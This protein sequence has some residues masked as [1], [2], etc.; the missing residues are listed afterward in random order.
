MCGIGGVFLADRHQT[1]D[2]QLL[3]NM[4]AIQS[5]RGPDGFGVECLDA[6]GVG[7][8][9]ARLS[10]ID[11]NESRARQPFLSNDRQVL[12]A[13]NG[14][15]YD[16]QRIRADLTAQGVRFSSKSDSEIL[17]RLY[18]RQGLESTLPLLRG[19]FAFA[20]FDAADD[21]LYL[22]RDRFGIKPQYWT[23]TPEG[24]VFGSELKVLFAHPAVERRFTS[25]GLFH[26]L[27]Q[28][29][30][31][32]TTAFA[33]VHQVQPGHVLKVQRRGD[34][35]EV[36]KSTY[37]DVDFPRLDQRDSTLTE[38]DHIANVRAALLEAVEMRMV[39][40]VPVGCYLSGGIDSCSI[41]G[42][43]SA[44]SQGPVKAFTIGFD[45]ARYD[46]TPIAAEMAEATGAEQDVM[47]LSG[48][49]LYGHMEQTLWHTERTIYN[50]LAVAKYLMSRHVNSVDYKVVMTGEGS[51]ELFG[52]Y[53]AFRRDMFLH[54][55]EA[56]PQNDRQDWESLLQTNNSLVQGAML[57]ADQVDDPDLD[58]VVGF[59]PSCLQPWLACAPLVPDLLADEHRQALVE[60]SPGKAIAEQL[61][62]QQ[63]D[64]RHALDK[65]QY[66]WIKT[67]L[68]GQIL[69]WGGDR[70]D[71]ANSMEA[72]PAFLDHHLAAAAVQVPPELRIKGKTEKY[73]LR[74]AMAGL[75]PEV[76]YKREKFAFMAPPAHT[77]PE[78]WAQMKQLAD[79]YL[80]DEAIDAAGLLSKEG[81]SA[82]FARHDDP[83]TTD[84]ERVQMDAVINHLLGV[85]MLHRMFVAADV[86]A[87]A[88][89]QADRLGWRVLMPV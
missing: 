43:A 33:G 34:R 51:D 6:A 86:P 87:Q 38:A 18:Q 35:L 60:Y 41:L 15:F 30:V 32:G 24:L 40:D 75:L 13:H 3:V 9:H 22:V 72:R 20:L 54:G 27:M 69:T 29:M 12:M 17:L 81:V 66:V 8:C 42:L 76:L 88:R 80:S 37:W 65:A 5:H 31:P 79:D 71:M 73:V 49:E 83:A 53:P 4:A 89:E 74:E 84:A 62:P 19:E 64:G 46:E 61:N 78:K 2:R 39:A 45:D 50:T 36:S 1:L 16:F 63:L 85:Q 55:L 14:E 77:E 59:T 68:E 10:I 52:G 82:L 67:M 21:C 28:T 7:F 25:E 58:A 11:L 23:M 48:R 26:Q 56:L 70:V 44:V 47:R 57:A